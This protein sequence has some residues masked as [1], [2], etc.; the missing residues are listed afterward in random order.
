MPGQRAVAVGA[1]EIVGIDGGEGLVDCVAADQDGLRGAPRLGAAGGHG[2]ARRNVFERLKH[3]VD[4][5]A[6]LK[7]RADDLAE[8]LLDVL[9]DDE[10]QLAEARREERRRWSSR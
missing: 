2:E 8:R 7:A 6:F 5:D 4:G 1:V 10:D 3:V 9:A